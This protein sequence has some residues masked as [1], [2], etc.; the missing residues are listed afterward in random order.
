M[1][2][3]LVMVASVGW[4]QTTI[5]DVLNQSFT[6]V[7]G[8]NYAEWS[9]KTGTSGAVY[10]GNSAGS[11]NSIQLRSNNNNSGVVSTTSGG[12]LK[13][14][15]VTWNSETANGRTLNVYGSK[16]AY[17]AATDLYKSSKQGTLLG[18]IVYGTS[19]ELTVED[20]YQYVG[21]RSA[22]GA[23]YLDEVKI[24][25]ESSSTETPTCAT[26]TFSPA[27][28]AVAA[29]TNV[30]IRCATEGATIYYTT[31]GTDPTTGSTPGTSVTVNSEMTIKAIAV[32]SGMDN[33]AVA[34]AAYTVFQ[35]VSGYTIDFESPFDAYADW[36]FKNAEQGTDAI[37]AH[38][39]TYYATTGG[40]ASAVF[41][42]KERV[43]KPT[44]FTCYVSK[45]S[46]N[47]TSSTWYV[48]V[49]S[50]GDS[51]TE[52]AS[53]SATVMDKGS[54]KEI[55]AN[56]GLYS[57]VYVRLRYQGST[58][59]RAVDDISIVEGGKMTANVTISPTQ[60]NIG[61][62]ATVSTD[63]NA[64]AVTLSTSNSA[65]ASVDGT[66][67]TGVAAGTATIT[68]TW[69]EDDNYNGG[70]KEFT[71]TVVDPNGPGTENNPYTVAQA[72]AAIEANTGI[73]GVYATGIVSEI[74]TAYNSQY[75]NI[76]YNISADG[77]T[78]SDQ[79]QAYRG[80]S[81]NGD[82]FTSE[83]DI[84]VGDVV[85]IYGNLKKH[86]DIYEFDANNQ[87]VSLNRPGEAKYYLVGSFN[88]EEDG[89]TWKTN[90]DTYKFTNNTVTASMTQ[91]TTFKV[92]KNV[93][94]EISWY[95]AAADGD[96]YWVNEENAT[97][98][99][100]VDG[101][102]FYMTADGSY[103]F[104][105]DPDAM[106]LTITGWPETEYNLLGSF[107]EWTASDDNKLNEGED[108]IYTITATVEAGATFKIKDSKG[109]WYGAEAD[110]DFWLTIDN[111]TNIATKTDNG[112]NFYLE[113]AGT[114]TFTFNTNDKTLTVDGTAFIGTVTEGCG[115]YQKVTSAEELEAGK[116]YL[117][118]NEE[119]EKAYGGITA[120]YGSAVD[121][122]ISGDLIDASVSTEVRPV[123]LFA[124]GTNWFIK[125]GD[126]FFSWTSGNSLALSDELN[127][128]STWTIAYSDGTCTITNV[129]TSERKLKYNSSSPRFACYTSA[130]TD[131]VLY[132]ELTEAPS[133]TLSPTKEYTTLTSAYALDFTNTGL[134]AY[135]VKEEDVTATSVKLTQVNKVPAGT[136]LVIQKTVTKDSY[137]VPVLTGEPDDVSENKMVGSATETTD[138]A[139]NAGYILKDGKF[140]PS[141]AGTLPAGK[142]YLAVA[143]PTT[144]EAKDL[145]IVFGEG[146]GINNVNV[147]ENESGKIFNLAGQQMKSAVKG[148]YIKNGKKYIK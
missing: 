36:T 63:E 92:I 73:T 3:L 134:S 85:V 128:N 129:G 141:L 11:Y 6:G 95:G 69:E 49:S 25:W 97:N 116:R 37:T 112:S 44:T 105:L 1:T 111:H 17:T 2:L 68:A 38:G 16:S 118:V 71:I 39:G 33:S 140:S 84:Q 131:V 60:I 133:V 13:K 135:I 74:V 29:G 127:N 109:T 42:T 23:M 18:T 93:D 117:I 51:W 80:K 94:G 96:A 99:A 121:A 66:T 27:A 142:A 103:T 147:N 30:T 125:D 136:G 83:D 31:D 108:G 75:G 45:L 72:R 70:E 77:L 123:A 24:T 67:V 7:T 8:T 22:S 59:V 41:Q 138:I 110:G 89:T 82:N 61:E 76:S 34:S 88:M 104:T 26:P 12:K 114:Y 107:N 48:E 113:N 20:E 81:Y 52:V 46:T 115:I 86:N 28:G 122:T 53:Q 58:A 143:V 119:A 57:N 56:L 90:D 130:Q 9:G 4:G 40:N 102:D 79:L 21:L 144:G 50:D 78:T 65:I 47:T 132:K 139:A 62:T 137:P 87:L 106:T 148:V 120:S 5:T 64:P 32:K 43:A 55:T 15:V 145:A 124:S 35:P 19:T 14:I 91:G 126:S 100:L 146:T 10:A 98:I 101:K 54:W